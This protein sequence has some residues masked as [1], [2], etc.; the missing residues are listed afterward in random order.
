MSHDF[1]W[2]VRWRG[3]WAWATLWVLG[4][5]LGLGALMGL[6]WWMARPYLSLSHLAWQ[7]LWGTLPLY[8]NPLAE[9]LLGVWPRWDA[10]H[11]L[12]LAQRGYAGA[13]EG[14]TVFYPMYVGLTRF[15]WPLP[16]AM[17]SWAPLA[18]PVPWV[19]ARMIAVFHGMGSV[20]RPAIGSSNRH[21]T[22]QS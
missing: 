21:R 14:D 22:A 5:R 16:V 18:S 4:L 15:V 11:Y 10:V 1:G 2:S 6:T 9:A 17:Q 13:S 7:N 3:P 8:T 20:N 19:L 12:N